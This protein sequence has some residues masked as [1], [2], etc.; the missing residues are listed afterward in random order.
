ML[1]LNPA[2]R[3]KGRT[4]AATLDKN[5]RI[6]WCLHP[7][8]SWGGCR[9]TTTESWTAKRCRSP[10]ECG[11]A[12]TPPRAAI[13]KELLATCWAELLGV[14]RAGVHDN[15]FDVGGHSLLLLT[16][17]SRLERVL[18][19]SIP[20]LTLFQYPTIG[21]LAAYLCRPAEATTAAPA[22]GNIRHGAQRLAMLRT[23]R[24]PDRKRS[25]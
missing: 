3:S 6:S 19:R 8:L 24:K 22:N 4:C 12:I 20:I 5:C 15:F 18:Q 23:T 10:R 1:C 11:A 21:S 16:M 14:E 9:S 2:T 25:H 17:Q 7:L 13:W